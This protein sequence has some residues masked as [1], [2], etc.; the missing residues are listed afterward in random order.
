LPQ[1]ADDAADALKFF[2]DRFGPPPLKN[3]VIS[4]IPGDF[5]QGFPGLVYAATLSYF[6]PADTP[7]QS[8]K[9]FERLFYSQQ[10][11]PHEIAHQWWGNIVAVETDSDDWLMEALATY[12]SLLYLE[13]KRG[14]PVLDEALAEFK[15]HLLAT[16]EA[17]E[18]IESAGAVVLGSRLRSSR[19]PTARRVIVYEKGAWILHMLRGIMGDGKFFEFLRS[20]RDEF[21][22]KVLTNEDFR[23]H[24]ARFVPAERPDAT[25]VNF[26]DQWVYGSGIPK[27]SVSFLNKGKA[28]RFEF[29]AQ[30][31][32]A[33]VPEHFS[34]L[35][36]LEIHTLPGRSLTKELLTDGD[37]T[38]FDV[39]LQNAASRVV[40]DPANW[41]LAI[42]E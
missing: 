24:A 27:L 14:R 35:V 2:M 18:P 11:Q 36:P 16:N 41:I 3:I 6:N 25:L 31:L 23:A 19:F 20:L 40:I 28:P 9:P 26:F 30:L 13:H 7:L 10:L 39:V 38:P 5:G 1:V 32:Q 8:L 37:R 15:N 22:F 29:Q 4:P 17:G 12:S 33:G 21:E 34:V 42:K